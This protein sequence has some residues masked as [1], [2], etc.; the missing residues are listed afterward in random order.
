MGPIIAN[1]NNIGLFTLGLAFILVYWKKGGNAAAK[2][3]IDTLKEQHELNL[4]KITDLNNKL[5]SLQGEL[6]EKDKRID[7]LEKLVKI[8]PEQQQY[9]DDMRRFTEN[10]AKYMNESTKTLGEISVYM[11]DINNPKLSGLVNK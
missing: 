5:G 4:E 10:V 8:A 3:V 11:H 7:L 9:M 2:D 6:K 1:A